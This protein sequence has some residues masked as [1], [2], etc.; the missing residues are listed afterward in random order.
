V[1]HTAS[2]VGHRNR[3]EFTARGTVPIPSAMRRPFRRAI[4]S[5]LQDEPSDRQRAYKAAL[6]ERHRHIG[7][8]ALCATTA[9]AL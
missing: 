6:R 7:W 1:D 4:P 5:A 2:Q 8:D 9:N 3:R